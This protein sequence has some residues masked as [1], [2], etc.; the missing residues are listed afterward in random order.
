MADGKTASDNPFAEVGEETHKIDLLQELHEDLRGG[1]TF[2]GKKKLH[3]RIVS[4]RQDLAQ[5]LFRTPQ[6]ASTSGGKRGQT[7]SE[8]HHTYFESLG[9]R[10]P[11]GKDFCK[12]RVWLILSREKNE[13]KQ[14]LVHARNQIPLDLPLSINVAGPLEERWTQASTQEDLILRLEADLEEKILMYKLVVKA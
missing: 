14:I 6:L 13:Q 4:P 12:A 2:Q 11:V 7:H 8:L 3:V 1:W 5:P 9:I 10:V